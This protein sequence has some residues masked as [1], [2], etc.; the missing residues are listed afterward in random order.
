[1]LEQSEEKVAR[2]KKMLSVVFGGKKYSSV[3][4]TRKSIRDDRSETMRPL[5]AYM[6]DNR[7]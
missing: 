1:M 7:T 4:F 2:F 3:F 6:R 5:Y